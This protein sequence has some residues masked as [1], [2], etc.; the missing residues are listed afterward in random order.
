MIRISEFNNATGQAIIFSRDSKSGQPEIVDSLDAPDSIPCGST[1]SYEEYVRN[2]AKK[3]DSD[4]FVVQGFSSRSRY[5][6]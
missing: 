2:Y 3:S 1:S 6:C 4:F 5:H